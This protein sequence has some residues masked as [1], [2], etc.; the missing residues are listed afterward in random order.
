VLINDQLTTP[1]LLPTTPP[2][3]VMAGGQQCTNWNDCRIAAGEY[4]T[5]MGCTPSDLG[6]AK[7]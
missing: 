5:P 4:G 6:S 7:T 2:A 1:R 3:G